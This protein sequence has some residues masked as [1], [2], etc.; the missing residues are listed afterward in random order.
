LIETLGIES[1]GT[2]R[3]NRKYLPTGIEEQGQMM[4]LF[5]QI[6][7]SG[8]VVAFVYQD[9]KHVRFLISI[10]TRF[11]RTTKIT[12]N[13]PQE[14]IKPLPLV[15]YHRFKGGIDRSDQIILLL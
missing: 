12:R 15:H 6:C 5:C 1:T 9:K 8:N 11:A 14:C 7:K 2:L 10:G 3:S 13:G 4:P